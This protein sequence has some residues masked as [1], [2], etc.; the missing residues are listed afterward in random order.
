MSEENITLN[1]REL[2]SMLEYAKNELDLLV[3][4]ENERIRNDIKSS[5]GYAE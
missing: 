2:L 4:I 5:M 3:L 1:K